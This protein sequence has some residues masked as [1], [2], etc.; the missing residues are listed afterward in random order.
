MTRLFSGK[1]MLEPDVEP[2]TLG[3]YA[4]LTL[5]QSKKDACIELIDISV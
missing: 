1:T 4:Y 2:S 3:N 5:I